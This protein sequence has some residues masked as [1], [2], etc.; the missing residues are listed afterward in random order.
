MDA[1]KF[2]VKAINWAISV[3]PCL[4]KFIYK[5]QLSIINKK[6]FYENRQPATTRKTQ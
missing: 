2:Y 6:R 5:M 3:G 4:P 1:S